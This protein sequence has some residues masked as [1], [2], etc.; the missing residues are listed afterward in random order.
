MLIHKDKSGKRTNAPSDEER[1]SETIGL[2]GSEIGKLLVWPQSEPTLSEAPAVEVSRHPS[3]MKSDR[4]NVGDVQLISQWKRSSFKTWLIRGLLSVTVIA[5]LITAGYF[6]IFSPG[7][8]NLKGVLQ[9]LISSAARDNSSASNGQ[10]T[11]IM[12]SDDKSS[13]VIGNSIVHE[14]SMLYDVRIRK[15]YQNRVE[16]ERDGQV[17]SQKLGERPAEFWPDPPRKNTQE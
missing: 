10:V 14:R 12:Y 6:G 13:A 8:Y 5:L 11:G 1:V 9:R 17:W 2:R 15:I 7:D 16:F 4:Q 3:Q